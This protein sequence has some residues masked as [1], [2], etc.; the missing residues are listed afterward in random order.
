MKHLFK[1][2]L[3][4]K[5]VYGLN[6]AYYQNMFG[7]ILNKKAE[8]FYTTTFGNG[9]KFYIAN[10]IFSTRQDDRLLRI[11]QNKP[12]KQPRFHAWLDRFDDSLDELVISLELT[13]QFKPV[14]QKLARQWLVEK[15]PKEEMKAILSAKKDSLVKESKT[16]TAPRKAQSAPAPRPKT[17]RPLPPE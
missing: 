14:V 3:K 7:E 16:S 12:S 1:N 17:R 2:F 8:P 10:P 15:L 5:R 4:D 6:E 11:I 13:D 9:T